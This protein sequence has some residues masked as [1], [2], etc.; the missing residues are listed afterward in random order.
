MSRRC[1]SQGPDHSVVYETD[2]FPP[3]CEISIETI[4]NALVELLE[5][6]AQQRRLATNTA[7]FDGATYTEYPSPAVATPVTDCDLQRL[8][9]VLR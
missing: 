3:H 9:A 2:G 4:S 7:G 1:Q 6:A 8:R 5:T